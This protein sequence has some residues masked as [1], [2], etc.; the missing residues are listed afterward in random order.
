MY[1]HTSIGD[2]AIKSSHYNPDVAIAI[3][4]S[5]DN[6]EISVIYEGQLEDD[7][8]GPSFLAHHCDK[9]RISTYSYGVDE[10]ERV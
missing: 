9:N 1:G 3:D 10:V 8:I 4:A 2:Q 7:D 5:E 6:R